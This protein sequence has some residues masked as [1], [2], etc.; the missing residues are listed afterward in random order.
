[1]G[2]CRSHAIRRDGV[3]SHLLTS[4][5]SFIARGAGPFRRIPASYVPQKC[6][7]MTHAVKEWV[8][9]EPGCIA[10]YGN[11]RSLKAY[12]KMEEAEHLVDIL[13]AARVPDPLEER[14]R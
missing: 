14:P 5:P 4:F 6:P 13:E 8:I 10:K 2:L 11:G 12:W 7:V 1:M 9:Q 3:L